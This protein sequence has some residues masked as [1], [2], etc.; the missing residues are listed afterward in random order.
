M[1][2]ISKRS[3]DKPSLELQYEDDG[4][5]QED[6]AVRSQRGIEVWGDRRRKR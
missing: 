3:E 5:I 6:P 1:M 4:G 2:M